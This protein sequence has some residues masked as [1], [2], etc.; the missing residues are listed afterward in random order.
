MPFSLPS[1]YESNCAS[2]VGID[3]A[4]GED[5][6]DGLC[7]IKATQENSTVVETALT[8]GD[9]ELLAWLAKHAPAS[10]CSLRSIDAPLI[11]PN[12]S[13]CRPVE[14]EISSAFWKSHAYCHSSNST[15]PNCARPLRIARLLRENGYTIDFDLKK[16]ARIATEVYPHPGMVRLFALDRI[17]KYKKGP[18]ASRKIE[19]KTLQSHLRKSLA[20]IFS[21]VEVAPGIDE[22][23]CKVW[24]KPVEDQT[25]A[26]FCSLVG[27]LHWKHK[28]SFSRVYGS[29]ENGF[30]L[31]PPASRNGFFLMEKRGGQLVTTE[32]VKK[33]MDEEYY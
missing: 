29:L 24:S 31:L 12:A 19:F 16:A 1:L 2:I 20:T 15:N 25:D 26:L 23:L 22:L 28:G 5:E 6:Q 4:W 17:I 11:I 8:T 13:G 30:I 18:V 9:E 21:D 32:M 3:L 14:K 27:Y 7:L 10:D 33:L